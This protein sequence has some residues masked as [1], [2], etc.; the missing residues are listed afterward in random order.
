MKTTYE[1][2]TKAKACRLLESG[3]TVSAKSLRDRKSII[4]IEFPKPVGT[5]EISNGFE[6]GPFNRSL[7]QL[8]LPVSKHFPSIDA[9][10]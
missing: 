4:A 9:V 8:V 3:G 10:Y 5:V 1:F 6:V 2:A 7:P